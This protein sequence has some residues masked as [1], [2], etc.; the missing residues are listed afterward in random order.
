MSIGVK[1]QVLMEMCVWTGM[2]VFSVAS[3]TDS[4]SPCLKYRGSQS[5]PRKAL[6][7]HSAML[8]SHE[9]SSVGSYLV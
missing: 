4:L 2:W 5:F 6:S 9:H 1:L 8:S 3:E 7:F